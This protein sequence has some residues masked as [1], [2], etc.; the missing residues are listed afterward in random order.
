MSNIHSSVLLVQ[1]IIIWIV[2]CSSKIENRR[3]TQDDTISIRSKA[4]SSELM[5]CQVYVFR[6]GMC[7]LDTNADI[8]GEFILKENV[9]IIILS[10][11]GFYPMTID[12]LDITKDSIIYMNRSN[13]MIQTGGMGHDE[14]LS[15]L[16]ENKE[17]DIKKW[18]DKNCS[19]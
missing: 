11:A 10:Y 18:N 3:L 14:L 13:I 17:M 4:D 16:L 8:N 19:P 2:A 15:R 6:E 1:I 12:F 5:F 7:V 9:D